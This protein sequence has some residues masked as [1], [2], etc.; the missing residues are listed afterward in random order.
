MRDSARMLETLRQWGFVPDE[1][2]CTYDLSFGRTFLD[3][4]V[5]VEM[6]EASVTIRLMTGDGIELWFTPLQG[7]PYDIFRAILEVTT[8]MA[9]MHSE[10][11]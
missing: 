2:R 5:R 11:R 1:D 9:E 7:V 4:M 3:R 6:D 8:A 10:S